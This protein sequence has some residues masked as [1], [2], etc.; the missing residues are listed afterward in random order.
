MELEDGRTTGRPRT[1][2]RSLPTG[3]DLEGVG[4]VAPVTEQRTVVLDLEAAV[5][6]VADAALRPD[7]VGPVGLELEAHLVDLDAPASRVPWQRIRDLVDALP[8]LPGGSRVTLEPG[9][10][11]ELSGPPCTDVAA[12]VAA[13]RADRDVLAAALAAERLAVAPVGADPLRPPAR[14]C[15]A[16]RYAAMEEHFAAVGCA[17]AGTAMMAGT[18]ALQVNLDAG[19][20]AGWSERVALAHQLG[21]TLV[22]VAACSPLAAGRPTGWV[23]HRQRVWS[24]LD[25]ARCGPLLGGADPAGEWA[26]YALAAPV[27]LVRD[28]DGGAAPVGERVSFAEWV[29]GEVPL[30]GR[31]PSAADLDYH[32]TT[33]FPP[34]RPRGYLEIRYLDAAPE[35]WWPA[36]AAVTTVLLDDPVAAGHAAAATLP[37]ATAWDRAARAGLADPAL[38]A[39]ARACLAAACA[40]VPAA[41]RPEVEALADLVDRGRCPG[42]A[43]LGTARAGGP[44]AALLSATGAPR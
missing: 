31:V 17:E 40:A 36:L 21:P 34:V 23:S 32:L 2:P 7:P 11:V 14:V 25:Q 44:T 5:A 26:A 42:D 1:D 41:L 37:V 22:A 9:G 6:H 19:P 43:L 15:P 20:C 16:P 38:H 3:P 28:P 24:D 35:P 12:A 33:L 8:A 39:A 4:P 10:Q 18:A 30:G 29:T 13:L 27:M